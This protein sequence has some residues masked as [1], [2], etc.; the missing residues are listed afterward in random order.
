MMTDT[1]KGSGTFAQ[2]AVTKAV[3][4][5]LRWGR[6]R[7]VA[8]N[9]TDLDPRDTAQLVTDWHEK[10]EKLDYQPFD[11][12]TYFNGG[13]HDMEAVLRSVGARVVDYP[14]LVRSYE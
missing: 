5:I 4:Q 2:H 6:T 9:V 8:V 12:L 13:G 7:T 10:A 3:D 1:K 11:M 14:A